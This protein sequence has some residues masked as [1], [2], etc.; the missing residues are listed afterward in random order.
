[1]GC[2]TSTQQK[3][4]K[5]VSKGPKSKNHIQDTKKEKK[6]T[7]EEADDTICT[8]PLSKYYQLGDEIGRG[9][10]SV[11]VEGVR[12]KDSKRVAMKCIMKEKID[13]DDIKIL[14]REVKIMKR[15]DHPHILKLYEV[16]EDDTG[17]FLVMELYFFFLNHQFSLF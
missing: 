7:V 10:F 5:R 2:A 14:I 15:L 9:G 12:K 1:M 8:E 17:F 11:V 13:R 4:S 6:S 16:Y 3:H